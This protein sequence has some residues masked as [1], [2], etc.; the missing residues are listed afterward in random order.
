MLEATRLIQREHQAQK[1]EIV[2]ER[3]VR[4][5]LVSAG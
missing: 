3:C 2:D 4:H 1:G 5:G